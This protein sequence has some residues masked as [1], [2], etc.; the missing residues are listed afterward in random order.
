MFTHEKFLKDLFF[1]RDMERVAETWAEGE[2]GSS[3][4]DPHG[5]LSRSQILG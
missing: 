3:Q 4:G 1:T 2:A 5:D